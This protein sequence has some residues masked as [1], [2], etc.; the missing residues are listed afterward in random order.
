MISVMLLVAY[1]LMDLFFLFS[2]LSYSTGVKFLA[3]LRAVR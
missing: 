1:R 3:Y 2:W